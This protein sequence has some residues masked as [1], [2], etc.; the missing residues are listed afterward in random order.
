MRT[1]IQGVGW[2][3][4]RSSDPMRLGAF[5]EGRLGLPRL[6]SWDTAES[7]GVMLWAGNCAVLETNRLSTDSAVDQA[8]SQCIPVF[9]TADLCKAERDLGTA[10]VKP[11]HEHHGRQVVTLLFPDPDGNLFGI[12]QHE[13]PSGSNAGRTSHGA[14]LP[15]EIH[16]GQTVQGLSRVIHKTTDVAAETAFLRG[17]G[18]ADLE[19]S[20]TSSRLLLGESCILD[21]EPGGEGLPP[22]SERTMMPD[23]WILRVYGIDCLRDRLARIGKRGLSQHEFPGGSLDYVLTPDNRLIGWQER[24]PYD[25]DIVTTQLIEDLQARSLWCRTEQ[26]GG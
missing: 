11:V 2:F 14:P 9:L 21:I 3:L 19:T 4:R 18:L 13:T 20:A 8:S 23:A 7:S 12:D 16:M 15:G 26:D 25:P 5:Y 6:R 24:K 1:G 22:I 17:L 10:G